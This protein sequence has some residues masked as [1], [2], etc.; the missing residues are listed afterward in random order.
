MRTAA[1]QFDLSVV[2]RGVVLVLLV[3]KGAQKARH[4][5][6]TIRRMAEEEEK[7]EEEH[8]LP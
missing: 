3:Q 7:E 1:T 5:E 2:E 4:G 6:G 8:T